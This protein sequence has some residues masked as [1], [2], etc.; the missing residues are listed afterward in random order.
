M[1]RV[2]VTRA[3]AQSLERLIVTHSLPL[4]TPGRV[5]RSV[6]PLAEFPR[7]GRALDAEGYEGLRFVLGPWRWL[8]VLYEHDP[9]AD[10]VSILAIEDARSTHAATA[11]RG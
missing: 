5:H 6:E 3:A 4:D 10:I 1:P 9:E 11:R 2:V 8:V 7:L